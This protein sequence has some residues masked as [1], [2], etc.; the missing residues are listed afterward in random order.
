MIPMKAVN[1]NTPSPHNMQPEGSNSTSTVL[2]VCGTV[3]NF[4]RVNLNSIDLL[5]G[6]ILKWVTIISFIIVIVINIPKFKRT[7]KEYFKW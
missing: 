2:L 4:I 1:Y 7:I 3:L 6:I 5:S